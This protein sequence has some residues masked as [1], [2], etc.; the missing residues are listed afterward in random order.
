VLETNVFSADSPDMRSLDPK[1]REIAPLHF[2]LDAIKPKVVV[3]HGD[4][5]I[6][7]TKSLEGPW[8][9]KRAGHFSRYETKASAAALG[10]LVR[11]IGQGKRSE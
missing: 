1:R 4:P 5:A 3:A 11:D 7:A 6:A 9:F 10:E 2:L 8:V